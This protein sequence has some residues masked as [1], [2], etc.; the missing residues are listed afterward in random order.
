[1][2]RKLSIIIATYNSEKTLSFALDSLLSQRISAFECV[3]ID[4]NSTDNTLDIIKK[5]E[6]KFLEKNIDF[7]WISEQDKG[8]YDAWNKGLDL[9]NGDWISFLGS[10]DKYKEGALNKYAEIINNIKPNHKVDLVYSNVDYVSNSKLIRKLN[11]EWFWDKFKRYMCIAHVGSFHNKEYFKTYGYYNIDYKICGD[12]EL[13]LRAK[14]DLSTLKLNFTTVEME[15][16]G[17]SNDL[18]NKAFKE[19]YHAKINTAKVPKYI[20]KWDF[21]VA[22]F[23]H[24]LK[25]ILGNK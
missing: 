11:G 10:D 20:A 1:M 5:F 24:F 3:V 7:K 16:G 15:A 18:T 22:S 2:N 17:V 12:Y 25:S 13:L 21:I 23:K 19:T 4:G 8:I 6:S 14:E 9:A